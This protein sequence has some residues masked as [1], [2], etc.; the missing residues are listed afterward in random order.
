MKVWIV[1]VEYWSDKGHRAEVAA[2]CASLELAQRRAAEV[3]A[4]PRRLEDQRG[5]AWVM[6]PVELEEDVTRVM[7]APK[8]A[9]QLV[10]KR[11]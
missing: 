8:A 9:E 11:P 2:V 4:R 5:P 1:M 3:D 6:E 7:T 10:R